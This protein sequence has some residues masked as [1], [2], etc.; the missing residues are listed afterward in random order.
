LKIKVQANCDNASDTMVIGTVVGYYENAINF[1]SVGSEDT[2][3]IKNPD[4]YLRK[5]VDRRDPLIGEE[6][7]YTLTLANK[8]ER[9]ASNVSIQDYF[10]EGICYQ[11]GSTLILEPMFWEI[12]EP[13]IEGDCLSGGQILTWSNDYG[14]ALTFPGTAS[15][16]IT[17]DSE[18]IYLRY[19]GK[20]EGNIAL[21]VSLINGAKITTT[22]TQDNNY[23]KE[24]EEEVMVPFP[25]LYVQLSSPLVTEGGSLFDYT[26]QYGNQSRMCAE[27]PSIILTVP[28]TKGGSEAGGLAPLATFKALSANKG[29]TFYS[30]SCSGNSTL[31]TFHRDTPTSG[32]RATGIIENACFIAIKI[33][34]ETFCASAGSRNIIMT[35]QATNSTTHTKLP[36]GTELTAQANITNRKGEADPTNNHAT[37]TTRV[38][39]MD[40]WIDITGTPE[41][42]TPGLLPNKEIIYRI[43]FGNQGNE[44][45]CANSIKFTADENV[46]MEEIVVSTLS[47]TD[48]N[49]QALKFR[50]PQDTE[51]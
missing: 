36:A 18:D 46:E 29:E 38:P 20:V 43:T 25:N 6:I 14:N 33:A 27:K 9:Y 35:M 13:H 5:A 26:L 23:D 21:G 12:G 34:E 48:E 42:L 41:G 50:T 39:A 40:L 37:S 17:K 2:V 11:S 15:G 8:G 4:L 51:I 44:L 19:K 24:D 45:S 10:P 49:G 31:P 30:I 28:L 47:I 32:G 16:S 1:G 7:A 3:H 22:D